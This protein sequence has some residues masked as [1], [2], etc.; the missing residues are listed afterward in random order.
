MDIRQS[1]SYGDYL[2]KTG[3]I[4]ERVSG[5]NYFIRKFPLI[6][7]FIKIQ[8][9]Q[10]ID[11]NTINK[12]VKK[13]HAFQVLIEPS[14]S[15]NHHL[16]TTSYKFKPASPYLPSKTIELDIT[17]SQEL[18]LSKMQ[19]NTRYSIKHA[20]VKLMSE[21]S[22][23]EFRKQWKAAVGLRRY[24]PPTK[25]LYKLKKA[26]GKKALFLADQYTNSGAI[27]LLA[28]KK[29]YYYQAFTDKKG[30]KSMAQYQIVWQGI[31]WAKKNK[32]EVFD[33]EGIY[34]V[35]FPNKSWLG[36]S[37]F[38]K[39]FGGKAVTY[40]GSLKMFYWLNYSKLKKQGI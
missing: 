2:E 40:P 31:L 34:D 27:F 22:L 35:R 1:N 33:F 13:Y 38:K 11:I 30:R 39:G 14:P 16:L 26:F 18:L 6:G 23:D 25:N 29:A 12:L 3:W 20:K 17:K 4:V 28:D 15:T 36:F 32:A 37:Y 24:V 8:R 10:K 9:P 5:V 21:P 19:K 7:S